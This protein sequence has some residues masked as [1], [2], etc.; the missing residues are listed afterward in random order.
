MIQDLTPCRPL[1]AKNSPFAV[2]WIHRTTARD[3]ANVLMTAGERPAFVI[4]RYGRGRVGALT[5][6]VLGEEPPD[7]KAFWE[8]PAWPAAVRKLLRYLLP[9][10][11]G[12]T[13]PRPFTQE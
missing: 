6:T 10:R 9:E 4:H 3:M 2:K 12:P 7:R 5:I 13:V 11:I 1:V 8:H